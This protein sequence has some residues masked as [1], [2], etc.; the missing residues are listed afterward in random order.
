ME[1]IATAKSWLDGQRSELFLSE[2]TNCEATHSVTL[3]SL[4]HHTPLVLCRKHTTQFISVGLT[5]RL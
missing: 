5:K 2:D 3:Y 4:S 1:V